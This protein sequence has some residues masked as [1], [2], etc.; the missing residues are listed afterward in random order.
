MDV[1]NVHEL[2]RHELA[3]FVE[4]DVDGRMEICLRG[5]EEVLGV[6]EVSEVLQSP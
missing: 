1:G 2:G 5:A 3:E 6:V 4:F